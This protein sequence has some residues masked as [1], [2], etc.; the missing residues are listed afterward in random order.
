MINFVLK[1]VSYLSHL[2]CLPVFAATIYF[3]HAPRF[4]TQETVLIVI[5][6]LFILTFLTPIL[7]LS[8]IK[9]SFPQQTIDIFY[10]GRYKFQMMCYGILIF[11]ALKYIADVY[12]YP[13]LYFFFLG[14]LCSILSSVFIS[15][16]LF[17]ISLHMLGMGA[18]T[19]F[20]IALSIH[21]GINLTGLISLLMALSGAVASSLL[22]RGGCTSRELLL[23]LI[24]GIFPQLVLV[25]FWL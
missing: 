16:F 17:A 6:S 11:L 12:S 7:A 15:F 18:I 13:E 14:I 4:L 1:I 2:F 9:I 20:V 19:M 23:G 8:I 21:F 24:I 22:I 5:L 3:T 10:V 25:E